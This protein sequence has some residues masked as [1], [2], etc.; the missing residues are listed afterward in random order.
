MASD[1]EHWQRR[2]F[3]AGKYAEIAAQARKRAGHKADIGIC[4]LQAGEMWDLVLN[5]G[6]RIE[7]QGE[8]GTAWN[9][10]DQKRSFRTGA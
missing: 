9:V 5:R 2:Q 10:I 6:Q 7:R 4:I 1:A 3:E 8:A